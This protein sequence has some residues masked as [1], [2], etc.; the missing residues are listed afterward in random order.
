M[1]SFSRRIVAPLLRMAC[2]T[3]LWMGSYGLLRAQDF[4]TVSGTI[5]NKKDGK[6]IGEPQMRVYGYSSYKCRFRGTAPCC[7]VTLARM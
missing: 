7:S 2:L 6:V 3:V 4:I 1:I 5:T